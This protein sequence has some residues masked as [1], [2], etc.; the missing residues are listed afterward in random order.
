MKPKTPYLTDL[1]VIKEWHEDIADSFAEYT[2]DEATHVCVNPYDRDDW[3]FFN[4]K[5]DPDLLE[6]YQNTKPYYVFS[7]RQ[8][9]KLLRQAGITYTAPR[10]LRKRNG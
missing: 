3:D 10:F 8:F 9:Y 6:Q 5:D 2:T 7:R 1:E 4:A